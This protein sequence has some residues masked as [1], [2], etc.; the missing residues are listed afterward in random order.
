MGISAGREPK[1]AG[2]GECLAVEVGAKS[3]YDAKVGR[4]A[5]SVDAHAHGDV[6]GA[7]VFDKDAE[8]R[9]RAQQARAGEGLQTG[10]LARVRGRGREL[11]FLRSQLSAMSRLRLRRADLRGR[12]RERWEQ[13]FRDFWSAL[14]R[15]PRRELSRTLCGVVVSVPR[16]GLTLRNRWPC[17]RRYGHMRAWPAL[18]S[19]RELFRWQGDSAWRSTHEGAR[20]QGQAIDAPPGRDEQRKE[21][22]DVPEGGQAKGQ[23]DVPRWEGGEQATLSCAALPRPLSAESELPRT[24]HNRLWLAGITR[25]LAV[26]PMELPVARRPAVFRASRRRSKAG[27]RR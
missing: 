16:P 7:F 8:G 3:F 13:G 27:L 19:G 4:S 15:D 2:D 1:I 9:L 24:S 17:L 5:V 25:A 20:G 21:Q 10:T 11:A 6:S 22:Q 12:C 23:G 14:W 26:G 18:E